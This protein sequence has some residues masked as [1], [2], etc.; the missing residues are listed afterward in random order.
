ML[1]EKTHTEVLAE[2]FS[3]GKFRRVESDGIS[4]SVRSEK[5]K[6][7]EGGDQGCEMMLRTDKVTGDLQAR[8]AVSWRGGRWG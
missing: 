1:S 2:A 8:R 3:R 5:P 6:V 7:G 4:R